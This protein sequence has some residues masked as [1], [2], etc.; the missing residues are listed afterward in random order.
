[1]SATES[2]P[3]PTHSPLAVAAVPPTVDPVFWEDF[4]GFRETFLLL[5]TDR[6]SNKTLRAFAIMLHGMVLEFGGRYW[7]RQREGETRAEVRAAVA[8]LRHLQG[9]LV[10][11]G[12]TQADFDL[13]PHEARL[14]IFAGGK[15]AEVG[16]IADE[17]EKE[18]A[19]PG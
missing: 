5:F 14:S 6:G 3:R 16:R 18:L 19:C 2:T 1:M 11:L 17:L 12:Q 13:S 7:P 8:D 9:Y 4:P 15:A 10:T